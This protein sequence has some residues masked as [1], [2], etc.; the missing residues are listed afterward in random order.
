MFGCTNG[1]EGRWVVHGILLEGDVLVVGPEMRIRTWDAQQRFFQLA[2]ERQQTVR[3]EI[4]ALIREK[5][6]MSLD[7]YTEEEK[8]LRNA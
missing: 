1:L 3:D 5:Q 7:G 2:S 8:A 4:I 6:A